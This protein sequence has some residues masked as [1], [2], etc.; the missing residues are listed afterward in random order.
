MYLQYVQTLTVTEVYQPR[1]IMSWI[2]MLCK[3]SLLKTG[4]FYNFTVPV[5][6]VTRSFLFP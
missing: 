6:P 3:V 4:Y 2:T 1:I 5:P